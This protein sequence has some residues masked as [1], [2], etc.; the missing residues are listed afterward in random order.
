MNGRRSIGLLVSSALL[1]A[2]APAQAHLVETGFGAF[3]DGLAHVVLT[4][5]DLLVVLAI[6]L[7]AGQRGMAPARRA[8]FVLPAAWLAGALLGT[9]FAS[10]PTPVITTLPFVAAGMLVLLDAKL[11]PAA[12]AVFAGAAGLLHGFANGATMTT[13]GASTLAVAGAVSAVFCLLAIVAAE[14]TRLQAGWARVAV[15]VAGSWIAAAGLLML[16]WLAR[17][18]L[19]A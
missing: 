4:P 2:S 13:G 9:R 17:P 3:Y 10:A 19:A 15:R 8:L 16:G 14:V 6:A 7:M 12:V 11:R 18:L 5:A 1:A